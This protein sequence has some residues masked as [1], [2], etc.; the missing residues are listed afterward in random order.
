MSTTFAGLRIILTGCV[1][2]DSD[3]DENGRSRTDDGR[4]VGRRGGVM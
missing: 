1:L 3:S 2:G 4:V